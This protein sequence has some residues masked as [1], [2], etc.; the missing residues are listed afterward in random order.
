M[1]SVESLKKAAVEITGN[2]IECCHRM[3]DKRS[4]QSLLGGTWIN[5]EQ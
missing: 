2:K 3:S 1:F 5:Q 4:E